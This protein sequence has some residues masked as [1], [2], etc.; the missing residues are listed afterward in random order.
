MFL[1][2]GLRARHKGQVLGCDAGA[3]IYIMDKVDCFLFLSSGKWH[4]ER[5]A[6]SLPKEKPFFMLTGKGLED[7]SYSSLKKSRQG[8]LNKFYFAERVGILVSTKAGQEML[9]NALILKEKIEGMGKKAFIFISDMI[10][11]SEFENFKMQCWINTACPGLSFD[12]PAMLNY[13]ETKDIK[14]SKK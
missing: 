2:A 13:E 6:L 11:P 7:I 3:A 10:N 9:D 14:F 5:I 12:F 1:V 4:A 8:A